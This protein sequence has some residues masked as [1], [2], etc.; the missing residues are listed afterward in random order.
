MAQDLDGAIAAA[1]KILGKDAKIPPPRPAVEKSHDDQ[2]KAYD[3][4]Q[5]SRDDLKD[6]IL[7]LQ[8]AVS[9]RK[10]AL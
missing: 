10:N 9:S 7:A 6:K 8:D 2:T 1:E 4:Y 5:K 3:E